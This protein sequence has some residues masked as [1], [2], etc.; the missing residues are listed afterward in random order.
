MAIKHFYLHGQLTKRIF[1]K[2]RQEIT[3][4]LSYYIN[5]KYFK[6][7]F[8]VNALDKLMHTIII[9]IDATFATA[10]LE[11]NYGNQLRMHQNFLQN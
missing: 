9:F 5:W 7:L 4:V 3:Y 1:F 8:N 10:N 11:N 2:T 6:L